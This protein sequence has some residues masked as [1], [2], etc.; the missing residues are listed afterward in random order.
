MTT[1]NNPTHITLSNG[2]LMP[3]VGFGT[4]QITDLEQVEQALLAALKAG[5]RHID[6]AVAYFN[7]KAVGEAIKK[8]GV[9]REELFITSKLWPTEMSEEGARRS[10]ERSLQRMG[11]DYIDLYLIHHPYADY[12]AGWRGLE[13]LYREG[14]VKA[15]GVSNM[16]PAQFESLCYS[17]QIQPMVNQIELHPLRQRA[18]EISYFKEKGVTV[19]SWASFAEGK[20]G[21]FSNPTLGAI[22]AK[23][24]KSVAQVILR[25]L[26]QQDILVIPKSV[27]PS[28]IVENYNIFDF[29]L[30]SDDLQQ[31]HNLD[32]G[33]SLFGDPNDVNRVKRFLAMDVEGN[34]SIR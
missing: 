6:T 4:F 20:N 23:H 13:Q 17:A 16:N 14:K 22:A 34:G 27:T 30:N 3:R 32:Q 19:V 2:V 11:L 15:I 8:S 9:P 7:E 28:R 25:W 31:I 12:F 10:V 21:M 26:Y 24:G 33:T 29:T 5:Y 1:N 18:A